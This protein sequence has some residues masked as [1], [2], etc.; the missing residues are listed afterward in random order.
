M[1]IPVRVLSLRFTS[2]KTRLVII[3]YNITVVNEIYDFFLDFNVIKYMWRSRG[4]DHDFFF[5]F[6]N[7]IFFLGFSIL[8]VLVEGDQT[9]LK[10]P[11]PLV[12]THKQVEFHCRVLTSI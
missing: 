9:Y 7:Y 1:I 3:T 8:S 12:R 4:T 5:K 6:S 11:T 2:A 10:S